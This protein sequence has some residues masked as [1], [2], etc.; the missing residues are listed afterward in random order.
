MMRRIF[1]LAVATLV[2]VP[3]FGQMAGGRGEAKLALGNGT[4]KIDYGRPELKGRDPMSMIQP[5]MEWRLGSGG[6]TTLTTDVPLKFGAATVPAGSYTLKAR[7]SADKSWHLL[8]DAGEKRVAEVPLMTKDASESAEALTI[9]LDAD[10]KGGLMRIHWA[11]VVLAT[12]F[13]AG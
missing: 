10:G 5:G 11:K 12:P 6:A 9:S 7:M 2:V 8:V 4:V 13:T 3:A 1:L